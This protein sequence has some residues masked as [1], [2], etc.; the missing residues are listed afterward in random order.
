MAIHYP[1]RVVRTGD[2]DPALVRALQRRLNQVA[3]G[4]LKEDGVFG[5]TTRTAVCLFQARHTDAEGQSLKIDGEVGPLTW[6]ALFGPDSVTEQVPGNSLPPLLR[7]VLE[8]AD[9]EVGVLEQ[10][11]Y[12]NSGPRV[13][14]YIKR[15]GQQPGVFWCMC[16]VYWCFDEA[17]QRLNMANPCVKTA[18]VLDHWQRAV[19]RGVRYITAQQAQQDPELVRPGQ[20]FVIETTGAGAEFRTGHTGLVEQV[21]GGKLVTVE[22]NT[23]AGGSRNGIGVFRRSARKLNSINVGFIDYN[24]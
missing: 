15:A 1:R 21:Y 5:P 20:V 17:A 16:F 7:T 19:K 22:G 24:L 18:G 9:D 11:L 10:P 4:P 14:Q 6:E 8:I 12:S 3:C 23:N 2:P 13:N